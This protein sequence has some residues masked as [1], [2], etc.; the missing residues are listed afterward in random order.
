[1]RY[2]NGIEW[3]AIIKH[4]RKPT[5]T[6]L[7]YLRSKPDIYVIYEV[8]SSDPDLRISLIT[9]IVESW[10]PEDIVNEIT[11]YSTIRIG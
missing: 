9:V 8:K 5:E 6:L 7:S 4:E 2:L 3:D 10:T 1:M 11:Y